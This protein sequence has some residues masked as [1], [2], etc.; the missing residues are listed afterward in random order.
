VSNVRNAL[1]LVGSPRVKGSTSHS[2]LSYL[3]SQLS[4]RGFSVDLMMVHSS[5]RS[6]EKITKML[7]AMNNA[8]VIVLAAP[9]YVD[10]L[11][12]PVIETM[13]LFA[14]YRK[15]QKSSIQSSFAAI[16]NSGFPEAHHNNLALEI[17]REF[18]NEVNMEWIGGLPFGGGQSIDGASLEK[19]GMRA[20]HVRPALDSLATA[21]SD[22]APVPIEA[23]ER[24]S[25]PVIA[26]SLYVRFGKMR[27]HKIAKKNGVRD[28]LEN[29][30]Y[31]IA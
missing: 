16:V 9:L 19:A 17:C 1:L 3:K 14:K 31:A 15:Q 25:K 8:E 5:L 21:L 12:A 13:E 4:K 2:L 27:W 28:K 18:A 6:Q 23:I 10:C 11:P 22:K 20:R 29:R 26:K 7:D 24:I 30:P